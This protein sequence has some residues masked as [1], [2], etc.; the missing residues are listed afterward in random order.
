MKI[1]LSKK[2]VL[3]NYLGIFMSLSSNIVM[4][5]FMIFF[6]D[7]EIL[8]LWYVFTSIGA[9]ATMFDFGFSVTFARNITYCWSGVKALKTEKVDHIDSQETDYI[10]MGKVLNTCKRVYLLIASTSLLLLST[11]GTFYIFT[12][13]RNISN[14]NFFIAWLIYIIA[15]FL[16]LYYG[17]YSSF[18][19][20]VGAIHLINQNT[21][22]ARTIQIL[23][24]ILL[25]FLGFG[26]SGV[27][28]SYLLYGLT[29]RI[30]GKWKFY[31]YKGIG[32]S[33]S[34]AKRTINKGETREIFLIVWHNAWKEGVITISNYLS[35]Q[36]SILICS[37]FF[38]LSVTGVYSLGVQI[39]TAI[40]TVASSLYSAFQP[41]LQ[42]SYVKRDMEG[43]KNIM[44]LIVVMYFLV[45][46]ICFFGVILFVLPIVHRLKP[47]LNLSILLLLWLSVYQFILHFRNCYTSY[48]SCTNR[49]CYTSAFITAALI[50]VTLSLVFV[51]LFKTG[52]WGLILAQ[53]ISQASYNMWAWAVKVHKELDLS[54]FDMLKR[55]KTEGTKFLNR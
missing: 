51:G 21:I 43:M 46:F 49:I 44:S 24:T 38:T 8:G 54:C 3:W 45:F 4:L 35:D 29:F 10:L 17:Y 31:S 9:I 2:D 39:A 41:Q 20:G 28:I 6:L 19:R 11:A 47:E 53:I 50:S 5:P 52:V 27:C 48:F 42:A 37:M 7:S 26:L 30:L 32:R 33:I 36:A 55:A 23:I 16:N 15:I 40:S 1:N 25:L 12:I 22:I 34:R 14:Q 18:L 13:T